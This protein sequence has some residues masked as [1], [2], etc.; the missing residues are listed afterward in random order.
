MIP[1]HQ[2]TE[3]AIRMIAYAQAPAAPRTVVLEPTRTTSF[4]VI[5]PAPIMSR[6][7]R[8]GQTEE[9]NGPEIITIFESE[10]STAE[11]NS[12]RVVTVVLVPPDPPEVL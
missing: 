7:G 12:S 8:R 6:E 10:P 3:M 5:V 11:V 1:N 9:E 2:R 4:P